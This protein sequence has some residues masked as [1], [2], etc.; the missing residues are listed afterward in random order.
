MK[1]TNK[2]EN[3]YTYLNNAKEILKDKAKKDGEFYTSRK[4]VK[5]AGH[6]AWTGVLLALDYL[7]KKHN[8]T[9]KGRK[10][11]DDYRK[12]IAQHNRK[13]LNYFNSAYEV[14]HLLMGYDGELSVK[15]NQTGMEFAEKII[16]WV[17][18]QVDLETE[19]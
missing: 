15:I 19:Q 7:M 10:D 3:P 8:V 9:I 17:A 16:N 1:K 2:S 18:Q 14:L 6:A 5:I 13:M 4:Y 12:F 11:V